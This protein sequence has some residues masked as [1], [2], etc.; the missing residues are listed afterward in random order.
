GP[1][2]PDHLLHTKAKPLFLEL[3]DKRS[4]E[5]IQQVV[6]KA[7]ERYCL[8]YTRYFECYSLPGVTMLDPHP[9]VILIPGIGM[10]TTGK[11]RRAARIVRDLY[12]HTMRVIGQASAIDS[13][14]SLSPQELCE[15]EYWPLENFKLT[16]LPPERLLSRRIA[17]VTG[18]AGCIGR[19]IAAHFV[20]GG[21]SVILTDVNESKLQALAAELNSRSGEENTVAIPMDVADESGVRGA[22]KKAVLRYGGLDM[23]VSNAGIGR[24]AP[25]DVL[26]FKDWSQAFAINSTRHLLLF[27]FA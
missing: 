23:V 22:F 1:F 7:V 17:L 8:D 20:A 14:T 25:V 24:S 26:S 3:P 21:A 13:Y 15:F 5:A 2:T 10:F 11:D 6:Q 9:R 16:L 12:C 19:A 4:P 27:R 18:A